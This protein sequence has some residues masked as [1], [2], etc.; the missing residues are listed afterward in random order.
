VN[1]LIEQLKKPRWSPYSAGVVLGLVYVLGLLFADQLL[2]ASGSFENLAGL[3]AGAF[4]SKVAESMYFKYIMPAAITWQ[5]ILMIGVFLGAMVA[6]ASS[7]QLKWK[8][9][10]DHWKENHGSSVWKRWVLAF[11]GGIILEYGAGI[12]GGCTSGL[13]IAGSLQ[14]AP[15]GFLFIAGLFASGILTSLI[16]FRGRWR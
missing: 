1:W 9:I 16:M 4:S 15:A 2:G 3:I 8:S 14:L 12:A 13:A 6:A 10:P 11:L 5:V 7:G